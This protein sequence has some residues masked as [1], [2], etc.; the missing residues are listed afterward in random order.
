M[1]VCA[2]IHRVGDAPHARHYRVTDRVTTTPAYSNIY[3]LLYIEINI[4]V[5]V[6]R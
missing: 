2:V 6:T 4:F 5:V 3:F 1:L